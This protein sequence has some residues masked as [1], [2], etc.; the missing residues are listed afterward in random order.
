MSLSSCR[1]LIYPC[2]SAQFPAAAEAEDAVDFAVAKKRQVAE[3]A[4]EARRKDLE[5]QAAGI[6]FSDLM[7]SGGCTID[8]TALRAISLDQL[9]LIL[10]HT[11]RRLEQ[12]PWNVTKYVNG[13]KIDGYMLSDPEEVTLYDLNSHVIL[14]ATVERQCSMAEL[15][16]SADQSPDF[17]VSHWWGESVVLFCKCL[18]QHSKDR[19]LES[20]K[21]WYKGERCG[22]DEDNVIYKRHKEPHPGYLGGRSPLYWICAHANNRKSTSVLVLTHYVVT[23]WMLFAEHRLDGEI[24]GGSLS[25]TSFA[26]AMR[27]ESCKGTVSVLDEQGV[28]WSRIW[29]GK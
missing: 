27:L 9:D 6:D 7:D 28:S 15:L 8:D 14:L 24:S 18:R 26:R 19:G 12:E 21:G 20:K 11:A 10:A 29:C 1:S 17:F 13:A 2:S 23:K 22:E 25:D 4:K 3:E 16:A 5:Q